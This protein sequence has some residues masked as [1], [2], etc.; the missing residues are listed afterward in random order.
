MNPAARRVQRVYLTLMLGN[1]LA[2]SFIWGINT[3]FL[4]DAGLSNFEAFAANA[5]F[6]VGMVIFEIPTGVVAD[7]VGRK[8]SYL[9]GT[10]TLSVTTGLYWMLWLWQAPFVWWA[11]VSVLLGLGF[12]FFS[13]AVEAW[14]VDALAATGYTG[15]LEAVFGRGLVVT[16]IA[17]FS[18]SVLGGVIAQVTDLGMP[19]LVRAGVLMLMFVFAFIVMKDL[20]FTPDR[21]AGPLKAI[22]NVLSQSIEH[23]LKRRS[24]RYMILSAPF[25]GGV[26]SYA[27]YALQPYL[28]ELYGDPTAY[29]IAG[30]AAAVL[31]LAQVAGGLLAP[32]IRSLF[33]KRT[34]VVL[35][36]VIISIGTLVALGLNSLFWL[37]IVLLVVWGFVFAVV[38]PVRQAYLNDM[39]P[40]KQRA[41]VLSFDSLFG[42]L[43]GVFIQPALGRA[44]DL[45]G[46]G[47][48]LVIG[49]VV[50]LIGLPLLLASRRQKDP[51]DARTI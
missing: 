6:T 30:L 26:G 5:F 7:T 40:S 28:L 34:S 19:F 12:T 39:I 49:A 50:E 14:L 48:S 23:G 25:V 11:L 31:S 27:F 24:V 8:A 16:G 9:L 1:T 21:S 15:S 29:S 4:L 46:Y 51:A 47:T 43:G 33:A 3:L 20:G 10:I 17:M 38:G 32:R 41:T 37:A 13:G 36:A 18:G 42:S 2:A 35:V 44:A 45:Q 22:R